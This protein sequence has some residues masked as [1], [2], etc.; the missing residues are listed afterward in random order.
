MRGRKSRNRGCSRAWSR[1]RVGEVWGI[2]LEWE[3][4]YGAGGAELGPRVTL[5]SL[6]LT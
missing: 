6:Y 4:F 1:Y 3:G 5:G 2:L